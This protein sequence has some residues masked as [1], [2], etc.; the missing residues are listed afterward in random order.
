MDEALNASHIDIELS[1]STAVVCLLK[2]TTLFTA[3]SGD[4]RAVLFRQA[5]GGPI[6]AIPLTKDHKPTDP[7]ERARI[8]ANNGRVDRY[9]CS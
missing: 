4:S 9:A 8:L 1:G 3:W 6:Q 7:I 5:P 2:G